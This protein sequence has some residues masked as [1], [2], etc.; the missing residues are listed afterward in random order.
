[1]TWKLKTCHAIYIYIY[2]IIYIYRY[3]YIYNYLYTDILVS[4]FQK[5]IR[6]TDTKAPYKLRGADAET[7]EAAGWSGNSFNM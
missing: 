7:I 6:K 1:M 5:I 4:K 3:I 2:I